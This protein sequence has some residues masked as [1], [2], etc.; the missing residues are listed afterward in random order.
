MYFGSQDIDPTK[1][2]FGVDPMIFYGFATVGCAGVSK[3][4]LQTSHP[5]SMSLIARQ[6]RCRRALWSLPRRGDVASHAQA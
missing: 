1:P 3:P 4:S 2:I 6:L 5:F